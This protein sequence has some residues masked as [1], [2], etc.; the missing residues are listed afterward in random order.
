MGGQQGRQAFMEVEPLTEELVLGAVQKH[1]SKDD[2]CEDLEPVRWSVEHEAEL[3]PGSVFDLAELSRWDGV[4]LPMCIGVCGI[5]VDVSSSPNFVP[6]F[7]YGKLWAGKDTTWAMAT[8][9]LKAQDANRIKFQLS[10]LNEMQTTSLA[11]WYKHFTGKYRQVGTLRE[12]RDWDFS[13]IER[14]AAEQ[15]ALS[16]ASN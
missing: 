15:P 6:G 12:F 5:V 11:S 16:F 8:A 7:G 10:D 14:L 3:P 13:S 1:A 9:S 4:Q 2:A